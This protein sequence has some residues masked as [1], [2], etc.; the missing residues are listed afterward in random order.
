LVIEG[1]AFFTKFGTMHITEEEAKIAE[2]KEDRDNF[3]IYLADLQID[4]TGWSFWNDW[5]HVLYNNRDKIINALQNYTFVET[6][7]EE[8]ETKN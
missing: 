7:L 1:K 3:S 2:I 4:K 8:N 6:K 5:G